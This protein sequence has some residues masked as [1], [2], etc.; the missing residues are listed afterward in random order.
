MPAGSYTL[1]ASDIGKFILGDILEYNTSAPIGSN[2]IIENS[3]P[4]IG[5]LVEITP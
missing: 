4:N 2:Y 1:Q 5:K 3:G